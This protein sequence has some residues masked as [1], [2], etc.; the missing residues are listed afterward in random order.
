MNIRVVKGAPRVQERVERLDPGR[1]REAKLAEPVL[2]DVWHPQIFELGRSCG[3]FFAAM[4]DMADDPLADHDLVYAAGGVNGVLGWW[5]WVGV[6]LMS[7]G[8]GDTIVAQHAT[9][10]KCALSNVQL[11]S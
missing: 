6:H 11:F 5:L 7:P 10:V 3:E 9:L 8:E 1:K 2:Q 4:L